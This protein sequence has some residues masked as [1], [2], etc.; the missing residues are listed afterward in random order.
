MVSPPPHVSPSLFLFLFPPPLLSQV[1]EEGLDSVLASQTSN[2]ENLDNGMDLDVQPT[3]RAVCVSSWHHGALLACL[4]RGWECSSL[5]TTAFN[6]DNEFLDV[7]GSA[8]RD[9]L[10]E[11]ETSASPAVLDSLLL[12]ALTFAGQITS[13]TAE[14]P[15]TGPMGTAVEIKS[16]R[17]A[18]IRASPRAR[19]NTPQ[20]GRQMSASSSGAVC[21]LDTMSSE[22]VQLEAKVAEMDASLT[23]EALDDPET[24]GNAT[25]DLGNLSASI[26]KLEAAKDRVFTVELRPRP[27]AEVKSARKAIQR[28]VDDAM[29]VVEAMGARIRASPRAS[30]ARP[31]RAPSLKDTSKQI[32][33]SPGDEIHGLNDGKNVKG[34]VKVK[35]KRADGRERQTSPSRLHRPRTSSSGGRGQRSTS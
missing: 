30:N 20:L 6:G 26:S 10:D 1:F 11:V 9:K 24:R 8:L 23:V 35:A 5:H 31:P 4:R 3:A 25:R 14:K 29:G 13:L 12:L 34:R 17:K 22:L 7:I 27:A 15:A 19:N 16:A 28:R 2:D 18:R 21:L 32:S 33:F